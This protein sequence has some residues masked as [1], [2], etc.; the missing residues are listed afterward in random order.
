GHAHATQA[1]D[2]DGLAALYLAGIHRSTQ[3]GHHATAHQACGRR[4]RLRIHLRALTLVDAGLFRERTDAHGERQLVAVG[5][6]HLLRCVEGIEAV[7]RLA[8]LAGTA[9][10]AHRAPVEDHIIAHSDV[11]DVLADLRNY[12]RSLMAQQEGIVVRNTAIAVGQ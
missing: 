10:A 9:L 2:G 3:A 12:T 6:S 1:D 8:L 5:A 11:S 4:V 7:L